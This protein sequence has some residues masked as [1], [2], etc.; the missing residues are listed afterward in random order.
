MHERPGRGAGESEVPT[1][2]SRS[3]FS[4]D[5]CALT[6]VNPLRQIARSALPG[7]GPGGDPGRDGKLAPVGRHPAQQTSHGWL[8]SL[9]GQCQA[10]LRVPSI[11]RTTAVHFHTIFCT[12]KVPKYLAVTPTPAPNR[13]G[14]P[15]PAG[16]VRL[17]VRYLHSSC[18]I[19]VTNYRDSTKS[20]LRLDQAGESVH[21]GAVGTDPQG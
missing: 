13:L 20:G 3:R 5:S 4:A 7:C 19:I 21:P 18:P 9:L 1:K 15:P 8:A 2:L 12:A 16:R 6:G 11:V 17:V 14:L 10:F